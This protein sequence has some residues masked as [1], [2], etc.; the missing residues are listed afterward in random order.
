MHRAGFTGWAGMEN[1]ME[2]TKIQWHAAFVSAM[3]L[4]LAQNRSDL[5]YYKEYNLNTK[6]LEVDL[7]V[8]KKD[9][10]IE[11]T[12]EIGKLFRGHNIVEYK[13]P[14]DHLNIDSF[15]KAGAYASLY[16]SYGKTVDERR[17]GDI[18]VT[19]VRERKPSGL[20]TYFKEHGI[21]YTNP[22]KGIYQVTNTVLFPTQI[23]V[24]KELNPKEHVWLKALSGQMEKQQMR[25]LL[26]KIEKLDLKIDRELADSVLQVS[27]GAN[28]QVVEELRGDENMCQAL[29][30]I[31]E[32]EINKIKAE[33]TREVTKEVT[34]EGINNTILA[35]RECGQTE[36]VIKQI[37]SK[38]YH[39]SFQEA[40][41]YL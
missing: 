22:Y 18:T 17:A 11:I 15:Y 3:D 30:E 25:E 26:E 34:K 8:I 9:A 13:S 32:P 19:L 31:M 38:A 29:L 37:I 39:I 6:P 4:E 36:D 23:I 27:I 5:E 1:T 14:D 35:L 10:G 16:K 21:T 7:L 28:K 20:F 2:D 33:V 24:T 40:E 41:N 12:N